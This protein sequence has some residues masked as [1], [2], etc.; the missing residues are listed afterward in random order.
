MLSSGRAAS[1]WIGHS[2][3]WPDCSCGPGETAPR[4]IG[5][6]LEI[7]RRRSRGILLAKAIILALVIEVVSLALRRAASSCNAPEARKSCFV[8]RS[9]NQCIGLEK[10]HLR[11]SVQA[12]APHP[13]VG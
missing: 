5:R 6:C 2:A 8:L 7:S 12:T 4:W 13:H 9:T 3:A 11:C 1:I 10:S